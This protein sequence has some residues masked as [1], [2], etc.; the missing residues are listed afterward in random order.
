[1]SKNA[2]RTGTPVTSPCRKYFAVSSKCTA[3]AETNRRHQPVGKSR[4]H[5]GFK[6]QRRNMF[7]HRRQHRRAGGVSAHPD[8]H[9]GSEFIE[10]SS[11]MPDCA[12]QVERSFRASHQIDIFQRAHP[13]QLQ[14][15]SRGR[16][17]TVLNPSRRTDE[18]NLR[19]IFFLELI[20]DSQR[21]NDVPAR[22][23]ARKDRPMA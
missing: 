18:Q 3:A 8:D 17:Q 21:R 10:H 11:R 16:H 4:D 22:P 19:R 7:H 13:H 1:M 20:G 14:R 9:I 12:R 5:V 23:S 15:I 2:C 6:R